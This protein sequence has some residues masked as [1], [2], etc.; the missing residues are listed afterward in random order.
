MKNFLLTL[1]LAGLACV[2]AFG[3]FYFLND[4]AAMRHAAREGDAMVW[5]QAEFQ[6]K[7]APMAAIKKLHEDYGEVCAGHC[8]LITKARRDQAAP[9]ELSRLEQLC[10][11]AM[12]AHFREVAALMPPAQGQR[13][14]DMVLPRMAQYPHAGAPSVQMTH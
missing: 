7:A 6:L 12:T 13:Y 2:V 10:V 4:N 1:V 3:A 14:L 5:L 9:A 11:D 8:A